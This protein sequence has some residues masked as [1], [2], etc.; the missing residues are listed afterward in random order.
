MLNNRDYNIDV[1]NCNYDFCHDRATLYLFTFE[2][3]RTTGMFHE[4]LPFDEKE[5]E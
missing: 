2:C 1:N 4:M 5:G 3:K